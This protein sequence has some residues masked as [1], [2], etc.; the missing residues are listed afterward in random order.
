MLYMSTTLPNMSNVRRLPLFELSLRRIS[1]QRLHRFTT[2]GR[3]S[4]HHSGKFAVMLLWSTGSHASQTWD[5]HFFKDT[6]L[7][8]LGLVIQ[9]GH[10][11]GHTCPSPT[12]LR[13]LMVFDLSGAHRLVVRYCDCINAPARHIQLLRGRWFPATIDRPSTAF[14]FDILDFFHKLQDQ[15][16][17]NPCDFYN[18][19]IQRTD[20]AG[21]NPE[22]VRSFCPPL[23]H[24]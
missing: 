9:L 3:P 22:I 19:I 17:C 18:A 12:P 16:K 13:D 2:S 10:Q 23:V 21:L 4:P 8:A 7:T 15:N 5:G 1:L 11:V 24:F 14:A 6:A 20:A